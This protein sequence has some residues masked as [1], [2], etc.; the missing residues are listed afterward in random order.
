[1]AVAAAAAVTDMV[2]AI[3]GKQQWIR[4]S[5]LAQRCKSFRWL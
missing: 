2:E 1:M 3:A 5:F 4:L